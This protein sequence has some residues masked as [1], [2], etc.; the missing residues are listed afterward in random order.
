MPDRN[1]VYC[2]ECK[3]YADDHINSG[4]LTN[5]TPQTLEWW[6]Q[7]ER[8]AKQVNKRPLLIFKFDRSKLFVA[9]EDMPNNILY[10]HMLVHYDG[11]TE[12]FVA[13]L[14]DWLQHEQP[15]FVI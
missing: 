14:E 4:I 6:R 2:I 8:Q 7:A 5:K 1:N 3:G 15:K 12:F 11:T 10:R 13:L 9:F